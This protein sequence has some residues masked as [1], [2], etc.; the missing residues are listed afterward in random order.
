MVMCI[1]DLFNLERKMMA[2]QYKGILNIFQIPWPA[3]KYYVEQNSG[4]SCA[5][6]LIGLS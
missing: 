3:A 4:S 6:L 5:S 1:S 2:A